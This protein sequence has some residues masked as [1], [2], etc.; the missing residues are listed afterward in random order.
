[1]PSS[2]FSYCPSWL[3]NP[4]NLKPAKAN[5]ALQAQILMLLGLLA[6]TSIG[7]AQQGKSMPVV[8]GLTDQG[9]VLR[10]GDGPGQCDEFGARDVW[11]WEDQG[12][13]YMHYDGAGPKGWLACLAT[14][15]DLKHWTK[16]GP[17][18]DLGAPGSNDS[19][20]ASYGTTYWDGTTWHMFYLGTPNT[21]PAPDRIPSPPYLTMKARSDSPSGP[22]VKEP[23]VVPF[24]PSDMP[25]ANYG[26]SS[27]VVASPGMIIKSDD[28]YL[29]FFSWGGYSA[30][31]KAPFGNIAI[32]RTKNLEGK[33]TVDPKPILPGDE[34]CENPSLYFEPTNQTWFLFVNHIGPGF[35]VA[36]WVYWS[37]DINKWDPANKAV[38]LDGTNCT[39]SK[40]CI[41]LPSIVQVGNR[42]A[43]FY[44]APGGDNTGHMNRD[45]GLAW[46]TLPLEPP[47]SVNPPGQ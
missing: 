29:M 9:V 24:L 2:A 32:A 28:K 36:V 37:Q 46:L 16:K 31:G 10:H 8:S 12:T 19:A 5:K 11:V 41:G 47:S 30:Q 23:N 13:Y 22:W 45:V 6:T 25:A 27:L 26:A 21:T 35:T 40:Q 14:S 42:L 20:S 18:L 38:V 1:M 34:T 4:G 15:T 3:K 44:D 7:A 43:V 17:V 39:W 33:W